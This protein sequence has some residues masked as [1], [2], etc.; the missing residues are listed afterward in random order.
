MIDG[1]GKGTTGGEPDGW[2]FFISY[3]ASD[4]SWAEWIAWQLE[5]AG[6][7]V[8]IQAWDF[9]AGTNW[10]IRMQQGME[11]ARR[12]VAVLSTAYLSSIYG[13]NEWQA[14]QAA[15]PKGFER[16]L[17]PIRI[18]E[19]VQPGLL[20]MIVSI[21]LFGRDPGEASDYLLNHIKN[22]VIGRAKPT[23]P[24][25]FP[26]HRIDAPVGEPILPPEGRHSGS[27]PRPDDMQESEEPTLSLH[28]ALS[29][30]QL[31]A[32]VRRNEG[33]GAPN[34][35]NG[36]PEYLTV[37]F[38]YDADSACVEVVAIREIENSDRPLMYY[39][40]REWEEFVEGVRRGVFDM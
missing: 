2:D 9:V 18:E 33:A 11:G 29:D 17:L 1:G 5:A 19:C 35:L 38:E 20:G 26:V 23:A 30:D 4:R 32:G 10:Q 34:D 16:K 24:P 40:R 3:T 8:L 39:T 12:T 27:A 22:S 7:R 14:A 37:N 28:Q 31:D 15:D 21:D 25:A 6:Y 13:Q 36:N